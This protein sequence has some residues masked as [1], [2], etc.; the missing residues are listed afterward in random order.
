[1]ASSVG[2]SN[3]RL[4]GNRAHASSCLPIG[5]A[6]RAPDDPVELAQHDLRPLVAQQRQRDPLAAHG[7][8]VEVG[9]EQAFLVEWRLEHRRA[10]SGAT[11]SEPPQKVMDSST[12]TRLTK[13]T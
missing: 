2:S 10:R 8:E 7:G 5:F 11:T 4:R 13:T 1:M 6:G 3:G 9:D 12:P